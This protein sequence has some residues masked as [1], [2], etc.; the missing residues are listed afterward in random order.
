[1]KRNDP[2]DPV[3]KRVDIL[4]MVTKPNDAASDLSSTLGRTCRFGILKGCVVGEI[5]DHE[6]R[7]AL[8][9]ETAR[10]LRRLAGEIRYDSV[11]ARSYLR[12]PLAS[13]G[14]PSG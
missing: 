3:E 7:A 2:L 4:W 8:Y 10:T 1:M 6:A 9:R 14:M 11:A 5:N 12:L 13:I